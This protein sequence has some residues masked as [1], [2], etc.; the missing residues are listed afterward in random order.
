MRLIEMIKPEANRVLGID[1]STNSMAFGIIEDGDLI[2]WG[3]IYFSGNDV[4]DRAEDAR[5]KVDALMDEFDCDFIAI[6]AAVSVKSVAVGI[7][8]A[9]VI[10]NIIVSLKSRGAKV[11]EKK[12]L[13]WQKACDNPLLTTAEKAKIKKD[14]PDKSKSWY[15][16]KGREIRKDKT[17]QFVAKTYGPV[18]ESDDV[19]DAIGIAHYAYSVLTRRTK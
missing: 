9:Y 4:F 3:Q 12:P 19:T 10:G 5:R 11:V 6:E 15:L 14:F 8:M 13:E 1:A 2:K 17:R 7:K 16:A 18:I